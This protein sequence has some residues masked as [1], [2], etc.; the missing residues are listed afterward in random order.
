M[1]FQQNLATFAIGIVVIVTP[2]LRRRT[3]LP[4]LEAIREA[5]GRVGRGELI[6]VDVG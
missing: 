4:A 6:R 2:Q 1:Q 3:I 5:I